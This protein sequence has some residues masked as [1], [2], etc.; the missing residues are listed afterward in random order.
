MHKNTSPRP[1]SFKRLAIGSTVVVAI[2]SG[3]ALVA[4]VAPASAADLM[5][6]PDTQI[7]I[8][9]V[10]LT[11]LV[12]AT[13]IEVARMALRGPLPASAPT[14]VRKPRHWSPGRGEG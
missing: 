7:A 9:M 13:M 14:R 3:A 5:A 6:Q 10:P 4:G 12:L 1:K 11:L 2:A 8:F